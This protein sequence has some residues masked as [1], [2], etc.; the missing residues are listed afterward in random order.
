MLIL[1][2]EHIAQL[3][4]TPDGAQIIGLNLSNYLRFA[5]D[6][7]RKTLDHPHHLPSQSPTPVLR[8][9][10]H[11]INLGLVWL[12]PLRE[13]QVHISNHHLLVIMF[14]E[15]DEGVLAGVL[16][17]GLVVLELLLQAEGLRAG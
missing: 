7:V 15:E 12:D 9:S 11:N 2:L 16:Q 6:P 14:V 13:K 10:D 4:E 17:P 3:L 5:I 8:P 1:P